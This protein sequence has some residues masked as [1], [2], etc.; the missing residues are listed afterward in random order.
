MEEAPYAY[1]QDMGARSSAEA[2]TGDD[3]SATNTEAAAGSPSQTQGADMDVDSD[4]GSS[5]SG[6]VGSSGPSQSESYASTPGSEFPYSLAS[7][8]E[9]TRERGDAVSSSSPTNGLCTVQEGPLGGPDLGPG[10]RRADPVSDTTSSELSQE[11][12]V[13][14][15]TQHPAGMPQQLPT[16]IGPFGGSLIHVPENGQ[17]AYAALYATTSYV[18]GGAL[19]FTS[20]VVRNANVIKR[21]VYTLM[22]ANLA[23][24]V[25]CGIVDPSRELERLYPKQPIPTDAA[26]ATAMLYG[27]Y[28]QEKA[29]SVNTQIPSDFW[30]GAEVLRAMAQYL[31]EPLFVFDVDAHNNAHVQRY[32]Y[33]NYATDNGG[34][35]ES[36]CGGAMDD[37]KALE[38]LRQYARLHVLPVMMVIKRHE[39]HFYGVHHGEIATR[40]QAEGD[41]QFADANCATHPWYDE[42]LAHMAYSEPRMSTTDPGDCSEETDMILIGGMEPRA[43][44]DIVHDRL[45]LPR[46]N[47]EG[48]DMDAMEDGLH[49]E[50]GRLQQEAGPPSPGLGESTR[51]HDGATNRRFPITTQGRAAREPVRR[52]LDSIGLEPELM[53]DRAKLR[54]LLQANAAAM[55]DWCHHT[56]AGRGMPKT[57]DGHHGIVGMM[58]WLLAHRTALHALFRHL[59]YPE[60]AAKQ[61]PSKLLQQWGALEAYDVMVETVRGV[62]HDD[63]SSTK[64][65]EFCRAWIAACTIRDGDSQ[66]RA[67]AG[68]R[69]KWAR[70][71]QVC[72][73]V[74]H[75]VRPERMST[76]CWNIL[77]VLPHTLW[78]WKA[79]PLG[80][81]PRAQLGHHYFG[82]PV[83]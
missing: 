9:L 76:A 74:D 63:S 64:T 53:A 24:D 14:G 4:V 61:L 37:S 75:C 66:D 35:H 72:P 36:G 82:Q 56:E 3:L 5:V 6:Y 71:Q 10:D 83:I 57:P 12:F 26:A 32:Y 68:D 47:A 1:E 46:L 81:I 78:A 60:L 18:E 50:G 15:R 2:P 31:R 17:C 48:F 65:A 41:R 55:S 7:D 58:P 51:I 62:M 33:Q 27:H 70:L 11:G 73:R 34:E 16:F 19:Q 80:Q 77:N 42:I 39:G 38:M 20:E 25:E 79:S 29:R 54:Q 40:W 8:T 23:T 21:S 49:G 45:G 44:L 13:I 43:R 52:I 69:Q 28:A 59:P 22:M 30:A 67:V